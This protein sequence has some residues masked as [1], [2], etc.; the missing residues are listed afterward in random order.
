LSANT[1]EARFLIC[2]PGRIKK[3]WLLTMNFS[4]YH[5]VDKAFQI[6]RQKD[7]L[8]GQVIPEVAPYEE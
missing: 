8:S 1:L 4:L 6:V 2:M 7:T 5:Q 3:R